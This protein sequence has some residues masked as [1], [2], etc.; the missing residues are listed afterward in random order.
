MGTGGR[1]SPVL[2]LS[3]KYQTSTLSHHY[4]KSTSRVSC[5]VGFGQKTAFSPSSSYTDTGQISS[6]TS[7]SYLWFSYR[8]VNPSLF[9]FVYPNPRTP[10]WTRCLEPPTSRETS[11]SLFR[12][13]SVSSIMSKTSHS[14]FHQQCPCKNLIL[15]YYM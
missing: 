15:F 1:D 7:R 12:P 3:P 13:P 4:G 6:P 10:Q 11:Q 8:N 14:L 9:V 2:V 5:H